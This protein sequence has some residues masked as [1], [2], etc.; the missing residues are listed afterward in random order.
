MKESKISL[1]H[2]S[3]RLSGH[4]RTNLPATLNMQKHPDY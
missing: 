2:Q 4:F 3:L 1:K